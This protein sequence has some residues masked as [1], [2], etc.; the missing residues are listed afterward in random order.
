MKSATKCA[1]FHLNAIKEVLSGCFHTI[2]LE[3]PGR[4][5]EPPKITLV[6]TR[7]LLNSVRTTNAFGRGCMG[8]KH[9]LNGP[10]FKVFG[11]P[12]KV[13]KPS[14]WVLGACRDLF[15]EQ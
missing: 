13:D 4:L 9:H 5:R 12:K 2:L 14:V 11:S 7:A 15:L 8:Y 1:G 10:D 3:N 6:E